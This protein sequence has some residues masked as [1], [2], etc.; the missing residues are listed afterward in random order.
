MRTIEIMVKMTDNIE[1]FQIHGTEFI[2]AFD[3][4]TG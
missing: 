1:I 4:A 3:K 2:C